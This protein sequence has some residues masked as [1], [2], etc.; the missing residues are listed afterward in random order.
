MCTLITHLLKAFFTKLN[1]KLGLPLF[2]V[3]YN[4]FINTEW[5]VGAETRRRLTNISG[6]YCPDMCP[7]FLSLEYYWGADKITRPH[8]YITFQNAHWTFP[9]TEIRV[10]YDAYLDLCKHYQEEPITC[11]FPE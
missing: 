2:S 7:G 8:M 11:T 3:S 6:N 5:G 9:H 10:L 4:A 1:K